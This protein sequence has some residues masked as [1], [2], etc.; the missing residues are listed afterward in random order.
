MN[1]GL[2]PNFQ[3][4]SDPICFRLQ[5]LWINNPFQKSF[6]GLEKCFMIQQIPAAMLAEAS[7]G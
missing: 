2:K 4:D 1:A 5:D 6:Y 7:A 3:L